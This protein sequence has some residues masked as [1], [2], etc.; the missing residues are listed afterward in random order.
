MSA[1]LVLFNGRIH[2]QNP[3][4]PLVSAL[5]ARNGQIIYAGDDAT[6]LDL[7]ARR[8]GT[9]A[10]DL[11]GACAIP[12][13]TDA[14]LHF[15]WFSLGLRRVD[16]E[17]STLAAA[18]DRVAEAAARAPAGGWLL[19]FGWNHNAW[20]GRFPTAADLDRVAAD[21]PVFLAAKSGHAAWVNTVGLERAGIT[22]ATPDPANGV[23]V[24]DPAGRPT[25]ILL[26]EALE[27]VRAVIPAP[28][29]DE[30]TTAMTEALPVAHRAGLT[31]VHDFDESLALQ[32]YQVLRGRGE[33][34]LRILKSIP[35]A[36]LDEAIAVGLRSGLGDD[37]L[38]IGHVKMFSDG[39]LGPG[40]A[41]MFEGYEEDPGNTGIVATE[42]ETLRTAVRRAT[43]AGLACAIHAIGDRANHEVL[44][45]FAEVRPN[46]TV[47]PRNRI[48]HVQLLRPADQ[49]RLASLGVVA[50][51]QPLHATSDMLMA[52]R[53][54]G[55]RCAGAYAWRT[56]LRHG[57]VLACGS[58]CPV[59]PIAPLLGIHAAVTRRRADGSPGPD[60]W[61]PEQRLTVAEAVAGFT[62]GPAYAAGLEDRLGS[63]EPGKLADVTIL[64]QDIYAIEPMT[65]LSTNV[66]GTVVGG[67]FVWRDEQL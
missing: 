52:E 63:L 37:W 39:A 38:R 4:Q 49:G 27:L 12:G 26:E 22:A 60:G 31:G 48:E 66:I 62:W 30:L 25:G 56:Q 5:A 23:I 40:T 51:M 28:T 14:H 21:R 10:V 36:L 19:G 24:R 44:N 29:L 18:V 64:D 6:A 46:P 43:A 67:R 34:T 32:A 42:V 8:G 17:T 33:L 59:E 20:G 9:E 58:D 45:I 50:S 53:G 16:V 15:E 41:W 7:L 55:R 3:Q 57:A 1:E 61:Y 54:W 11:R 13:L 35:A 2:T 47:R 65:I